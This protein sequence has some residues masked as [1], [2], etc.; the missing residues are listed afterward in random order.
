MISSQILKLKNKYFPFMK[1]LEANV[2][3]PRK[4]DVYLVSYPKS[5]NT[6][7]RYLLAYAIW[8]ENNQ[9]DLRDMASLIPSYGIPYDAEMML[10]E[11]SPCN[12]LKNRIIKQHFPYNNQAKKFTNKVV[13]ICRDGRDALVSYW[14]YC[15]QRDG[16]NIPLAEFIKKSS[17]H[18]Y[19]PWRNHV[20][21]WLESP[22]KEKIIVRY[23]DMLD[24]PELSL[25]NV[26]EFLDLYNDTEQV[27]TAVKKASFGA[28]RS[29][30]QNKSF[31]LDELKNV[32]FVRKGKS[33]E[34]ENE[35]QDKDLESFCSY[36]GK[37]IL[38]L[39][40]NW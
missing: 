16:T 30:E 3:N 1:I 17:E 24:N 26:L 35:F 34:W 32:T 27:S 21:S 11:D 28:M 29:I 2:P 15:N 13:Y 20:M 37:G 33:G 40:Y 36:H 19:G 5:G 10:K 38:T 18:G 6:W 4:T 39:G 12:K 23:E 8:P 7:M 25:R 31:G 22:V 14:Y 9:L